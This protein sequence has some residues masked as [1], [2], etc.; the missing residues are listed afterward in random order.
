MYDFSNKIAVITGADRGIGKGIAEAF[1][2]L[3][4]KVIGTYHSN[5]NAVEK[6]YNKNKIYS[7]NVDF[8][9]LDVSDYH[10]VEKFYH[11][12]E[13]TYGTFHIL[14]NN[15]GIRKDAIL[16]MMKEPDWRRVLDV[17]LSGVF[18]MC[19]FAI[20]SFISQKYGRIINITSP[21][22]KIG[23]AGQAN[24]A[25]SKAGMVALSKS[26][27]KEVAKKGITVNCVSPG[28]IDTEFINDLS[29]EQRKNYRMNIP[30]K[31]FGT[32]QE[33]AWAVIFLASKEASYIT[34]TTLEVTG[35]L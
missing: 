4:A 1:L 14:I 23:F 5:K 33:V 32:P 15:S 22:G 31:R 17:N 9:Q 29:E 24:Y 30:L 21:S 7:Q 25:A 8:Q 12:L 18:Y 10:Q 34:G 2:P 6:F 26:L 28:F 16:G 35:G 20:R 19:K 27:S 11:Y 3:G 13:S